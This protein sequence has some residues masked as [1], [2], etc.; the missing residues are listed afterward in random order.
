VFEQLALMGADPGALV[1]KTNMVVAGIGDEESTP[2]DIAGRTVR[3]LRG[4]VPATVPGIVFLSGGQ[5]NERACKNLAAITAEAADRNDTTWPLSF[6]FGRALVD[7]ALR[8]WQGDPEAVPAAQ[9]VL[10]ANCARAAAATS[11]GMSADG[12]R[13]VFAHA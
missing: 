7:D 5:S 1:L 2:D 9:S 13:Q 4:A 3:V 12:A 6:S 8:T 10:A 11:A